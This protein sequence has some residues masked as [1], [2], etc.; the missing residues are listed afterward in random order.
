MTSVELLAPEDAFL[1]EILQQPDAISAAGLGLLAQTELLTELK[2]LARRASGL[3][4]VLT[5]MG[6][7]LD[8]LQALDSTLARAGVNV[9]TINTAELVHFR[10]PS[11]QPHGV[12]VAVS[13]SGLSAEIVRLADELTVRGDVE[14]IAVTNGR[15]N[16]LARSARV[17]LDMMAGAEAGPATKTFAATTVLLSALGRLL[18][19]RLDPQTAVTLTSGTAE[20]S[21]LALAAALD[22]A[23][24]QA[25]DLCR[26]ADGSSTIAIVGRGVAI[27]TAELGG[28]VLKE[29]ARVAA[30]SMDGAEFRH[31]PLELAG[32]SLAVVVVSLE[33]VS[34]DL[35]RRLM[36]DLSSGGSAVLAVGLAD[37]QSDVRRV[38]IEPI[39]ALIDTARAALPL[40][41]LA[42]GLAQERHPHPGRFL[43]GSKVTTQE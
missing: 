9:T 33:P 31:G 1:T 32:P 41:L 28:L 37:S 39:D 17:S 10:L 43:V 14:L 38:I 7:S 20:R 40:Q 11:V 16:P 5:G 3:P 36:V 2:A 42:W 30:L 27:G 12:V 29:A 18:G 4:L 24:E 6:S 34:L 23:R 35:D 15:D 21:A 19:D 8:A 25:S 22:G 13:Q 26:W